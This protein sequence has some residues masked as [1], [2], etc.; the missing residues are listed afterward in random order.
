[1]RQVGDR[2]FHGGVQLTR[3]G[4]LV[5]HLREAVVAKS[6]L[7]E[8]FLGLFN[9]FVFKQERLALIVS[10][11]KEVCAIIIH[12]LFLLCGCLS[13]YLNR[14]LEAALLLV[15]LCHLLIVQWTR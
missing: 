12:V 8:L 7:T 2:R 11:L 1:M 13:L 10:L 6:L 9:L 14:S 3:M 5:L 4:A 15:E